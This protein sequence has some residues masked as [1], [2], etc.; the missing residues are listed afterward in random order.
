MGET[1]A[2]PTPSRG[3]R[4]L[5]FTIRAFSTEATVYG[6][7]LV[8]ALIAVGWKFDTDLEVL[9]FIVGTTLIFWITHVYARTA[10]A[11]NEHADEP[12][13]VGRAFREAVRHS[14]G[15]LL[16]MLLPAV[17]LALAAVGWL[18]EYVAYYIAL[19]VSIGMLA[20]IGYIV[21]WRNKRPWWRRILSALITGV[22]GL[23]VVGLGILAH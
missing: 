18:D 20:V 2:Q 3:A 5:D 21:A 12:V 1:A 11:S 8:S 10:V 17:F 15:M 14:S 6:I 19:W 7:V 9:L 4:A 23:I 13:S 16:A 22:F